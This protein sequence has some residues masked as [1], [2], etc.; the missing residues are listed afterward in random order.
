MD[1]HYLH[2]SQL[3]DENALYHLEMGV[4]TQTRDCKLNLKG[5][6]MIDQGRKA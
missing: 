2:E 5:C 1:N 6:E 3:Q 4:G